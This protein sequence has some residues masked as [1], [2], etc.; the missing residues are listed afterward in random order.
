MDPDAG[1]IARDARLF[2]EVLY[3][4]AVDL[5]PLDRLSIFGLEIAGETRDALADDLM[6]LALWILRRLGARELALKGLELS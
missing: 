3:G 1:V 2:G 4:D 5:D 6:K